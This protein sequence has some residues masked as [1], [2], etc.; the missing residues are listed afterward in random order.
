MLTT[1]VKTGGTRRLTKVLS[2]TWKKGDGEKMGKVEER[3]GVGLV[4]RID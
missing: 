3:D 1:I 2:Q 4:K